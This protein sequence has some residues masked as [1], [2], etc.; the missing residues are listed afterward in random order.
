[1]IFFGKKLQNTPSN[2]DSILEG[3]DCFE[4]VIGPDGV[5]CSVLPFGSLLPSS[6]APSFSNTSAEGK[7][8]PSALLYKCWRDRRSWYRVEPRT[9]RGQCGMPAGATTRNWLEVFNR[10][11]ANFHPCS[12]PAYAPWLVASLRG[13][14]M[15]RSE[16]SIRVTSPKRERAKKKRKHLENQFKQE[17]KRIKRQES[18]RRRQ[19]QW[20]EEIR[21]EDRRLGR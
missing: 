5:S 8:P 16:G 11:L 17:A 18:L 1:M 10:A 6:G 7:R 15:K 2:V 14:C 13:S 20:E 4:Y 9:D 3:V 12:T 19:E 21:R